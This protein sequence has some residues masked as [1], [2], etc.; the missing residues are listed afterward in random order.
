[1]HS[2]NA[3]TLKVRLDA[4]KV[5]KKNPCVYVWRL[6]IREYRVAERKQVSRM[7][8]KEKKKQQRAQEEW[9]NAASIKCRLILCAHQ[10]VDT[11]G[12]VSN[13]HWNAFVRNSVRFTRWP[14]IRKHPWNTATAHISP[15][16]SRIH[17]STVDAV[18]NETHELTKSGCSLLTA[19][20]QRNRCIANKSN[21]RKLAARRWCIFFL[22]FSFSFSFHFFLL[23]Q[24]WRK[25]DKRTRAETFFQPLNQE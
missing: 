14:E 12:F 10:F 19:D 18:K 7:I 23:L 15:A 3:T 9:A 24:N 4:L 11:S 2:C 17:K 16:H 6:S 25:V 1:M 22:I 5:I 21:D 8:R 20:W 13:D